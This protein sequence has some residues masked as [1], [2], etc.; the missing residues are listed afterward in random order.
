MPAVGAI[1]ASEKA[2]CRTDDIG[3]G[4]LFGCDP[5]PELAGEALSGAFR[6]VGIEMAVFKADH[7]AE[8]WVVQRTTLV[9]LLAVELVVIMPDR[10]LDDIMLRVEGL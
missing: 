10:C 5:S 9:E 3:L 8:R 2:R 6:L 4:T 1:L 7:L